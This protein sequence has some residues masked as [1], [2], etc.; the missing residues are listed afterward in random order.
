MSYMRKN[1]IL[2]TNDHVMK[3]EYYCSQLFH[4]LTQFCSQYKRDKASFFFF[5]FFTTKKRDD[6]SNDVTLDVSRG[7]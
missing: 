4:I 1:N 5:I 2:S 3:N 7:A 6:N